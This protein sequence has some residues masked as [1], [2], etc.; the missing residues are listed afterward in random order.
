MKRTILACILTIGVAYSAHASGPVT[1]NISTTPQYMFNN[2]L[3]FNCEKKISTRSWLGAGLELYYGPVNNDNSADGPKST[4]LHFNTA[5]NDILAGAGLNLEYKVFAR[6][7]YKYHGLYMGYGLSYNY[8]DIK[9]QDYT[10]VISDINGLSYYNYEVTT[11]HKNINR[12]EGYLGF[13]YITDLDKNIYMDLYLG[14]GYTESQ[15][16]DNLGDGYRSF[17]RTFYDFEYSGVHPVILAKLGYA[18]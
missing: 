8:L 18:F 10:W 1:W 5:H 17:K 12:Y 6:E 13:G 7:S 14:G 9:Y 16:Q 4:V 2:C 11:G 15:S 3:K